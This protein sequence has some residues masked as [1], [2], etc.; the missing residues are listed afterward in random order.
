MRGFDESSYPIL[1]EMTLIEVA[2]ER[3]AEIYKP[4]LKE[5]FLELASVAREH[6]WDTVSDYG[7]TK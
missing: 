4:G 7:E 1:G 3:V 5:A 2:C 6:K